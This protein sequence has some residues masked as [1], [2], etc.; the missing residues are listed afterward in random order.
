MSGLYLPSKQAEYEIEIKRS[1]FRAVISRV[2]NESEAADFIESV[3]KNSSGARHN[4]WAWVI[5]RDS[6]RSSDDGEPAGT[7]GKPILERITREELNRCVIVVTRWFGGI[8]LGTGG[9]VRAYSEAAAGAVAAAGKTTASL[10]AVYRING[11][12]SDYGRIASVCGSFGGYISGTENTDSVVFTVELPE[13]S[14][15]GFISAVS[16]ASSGRL[17][18]E[19][20]GL[21]KI[22]AQNAV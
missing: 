1:R 16:D 10:F 5:S 15:D 21:R 11:G 4:C 6:F 7:A 2:D 9:L 13:D 17:T 12:Y 14:T 8:L 20:T 22:V 3:R 19:D 18:P